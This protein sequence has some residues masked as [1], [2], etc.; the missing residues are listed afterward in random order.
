MSI[1][2]KRPPGIHTDLVFKFRLYIIDQDGKIIQIEKKLYIGASLAAENEQYLKNEGITHI[3]NLSNKDITY[4]YVKNLVH[5]VHQDFQVLRVYIYDK[6]D[7]DIIPLL[8]ITS[9]F[10]DCALR[11]GKVFIHWYALCL[12]LRYSDRGFSRSPSVVIAYLIDKY[13][14]S[15]DS[16]YKI[17]SD[18]KYIRINPSIFAI[19][20]VIQVFRNN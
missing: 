20:H 15:Y 6:C 17:V 4:K 18:K 11:I 10:V 3:I 9:T 1:L 19:K 5:C 12:I 13:N 14:Y 8:P 7:S 2:K 16:A